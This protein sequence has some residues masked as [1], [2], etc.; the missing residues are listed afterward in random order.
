[1]CGWISHHICTKWI[2]IFLSI[3]FK[4]LIRKKIVHTYQKLTYTNVSNYISDSFIKT[5]NNHTHNILKSSHSEKNIWEGGGITSSNQGKQGRCNKMQKHFL[6]IFF[7]YRWWTEIL[8]WLIN[9]LY[10]I[11]RQ[12]ML[13]K[14]ILFMRKGILSIFE[15]MVQDSI[16]K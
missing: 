2:S 1:M 9:I 10:K 8:T 5:R 15:T 14:F 11:F 16:F 13:S 12:Y 7:Y 3:I 4:D 6:H